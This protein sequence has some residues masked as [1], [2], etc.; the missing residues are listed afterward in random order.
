MNA[1]D[2][3]SN[4]M[5]YTFC[6]YIGLKAIPIMNCYCILLIEVIDFYH[7]VNTQQFYDQLYSCV[8]TNLQMLIFNF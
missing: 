7:T 4:T 3:L 8:V 1:Y 6:F 5:L 2:W